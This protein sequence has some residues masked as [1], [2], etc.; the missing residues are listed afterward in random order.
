VHYITS[1]V[2]ASSLTKTTLEYG[3][4]LIYCM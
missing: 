4:S 1:T 2:I 3:T